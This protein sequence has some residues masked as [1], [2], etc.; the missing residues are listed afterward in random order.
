MKVKDFNL[1]VC[2]R[3]FTADYPEYIKFSGIKRNEI[4][5]VDIS[6]FPLEERSEYDE[7]LILAPNEQIL[8]VKYIKNNKVLINL[9]G[10]EFC[11]FDLSEGGNEDLLFPGTSSLTNCG[12]NTF[13]KVFTNKDLNKYGLI[14][15]IEKAF[16]IKN[17][18]PKY[19]PDEPHAYCAVFA[20]WRK[21]A[22]V[23]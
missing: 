18:L 15:N 5:S 11:G 12:N 4:V 16:Q 21:I 23:T 7:E 1:F 17:L 14:E 13:E 8:A 3:F 22:T 10:F 2:K 9:D 20:I 19:Y 6:L